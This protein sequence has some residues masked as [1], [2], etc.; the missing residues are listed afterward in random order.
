MNRLLS[1]GYV[2]LGKSASFWV[3][4][5]AVFLSSFIGILNC[6]RSARIMAS[7]GFVVSLERYYFNQAPFIGLFIPVFI[8]LFL[9]TEYSDGTLR[10]KLIVGHTRLHIFLSNFILC[11]FAG[12]VFDA[13]W[14]LGGVPGFF[15]IQ[16]REMDLWGYLLYFLIIV[17][18]TAA[19]SAIYTL[20]GS[21][22]SNKALTVIFSLVT[23]LCMLFTASALYDRLCEPKF[24]GGM[25]Y[26]NGEFVNLAQ[27]PNP[28][29]LTGMPRQICEWFLDL[30]PTGQALLLA[31][32]A[33][34]HPVRQILSAVVLTIVA[35]MVGYVLFSKKDIK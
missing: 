2:R 26:I 3:V 11:F 34:E 30:L 18:F 4:T 8:S 31:E 29:Y 33:I 7:E 10:N 28:L 12:L 19:F 20:I 17:G 14:V 35:L 22:C 9:G 16:P 21:L 5:L 24:H 25:A 13:V 1:A 27:E 32:M 23:W 15:M 6:A